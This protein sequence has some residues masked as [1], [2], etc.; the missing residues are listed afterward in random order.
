MTNPWPDWIGSYQLPD[1]PPPIV[2][3]TEGNWHSPLIRT[4]PRGHAHVVPVHIIPPEQVCV[5]AVHTPLTNV[6]PAGHTHAEPFQYELPVHVGGGGGEVPQDE[7]R[8]EG[9]T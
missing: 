6:S 2:N 1:M 5:R 7:Q 8:H 4:S 9:L 3:P